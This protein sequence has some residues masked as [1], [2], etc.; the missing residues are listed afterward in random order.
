MNED[1][2]S[3]NRGEIVQVIN[4]DNERNK[5]LVFKPTV[6]NTDEEG[7]I[8]A[9]VFGMLLVAFLPKYFVC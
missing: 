1:E 6:G 4:A 9:V 3:C 8:P 2:L 7:W 5:L